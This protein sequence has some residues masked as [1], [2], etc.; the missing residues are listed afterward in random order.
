MKIIILG[1]LLAT[2]VLSANSLNVLNGFLSETD[3]DYS[4]VKKQNV[5]KESAWTKKFKEK[6]KNS[7]WRKRLEAKAEDSS[8]RK[9]FKKKEEPKGWRRKFMERESSKIWRKK[10]TK[11]KT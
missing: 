5:K 3:K 10:S 2:S 9:K 6:Q 11:S 4:S 8:W 1:I 7:A